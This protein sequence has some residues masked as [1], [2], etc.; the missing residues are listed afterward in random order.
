MRAYGF[1]FLAFIG[2][3]TAW[4]SAAAPAITVDQD[5]TAHFP[6]LDIPFS[7]FASAEA[8]K[9]YLGK[10]AAP[11]L[12]GPTPQ[13]IASVRENVTRVWTPYLD[14]DIQLYPVTIETATIAGVATDVVTPVGGVAPKNRDKILINLH[15]GGFFL[16][17]HI[18]GKIESVPIAGLGKYK[19]ITV[20][21]RQGTENKFPAASEDV[22]A[23]Y[24]ELLKQYK[25]KNI[26][27]Y[28]CSAGGFLTAEAMAWF[29]KEKL[30]L[31]GAIGIFCAS[32]G[33]WT[34]GDSTYFTAPYER[35]MPIVKASHPTVWDVAYF[36]DA[37]M[38][39]PLV[40]PIR[41]QEML[42]KFPPTLMITATR[43]FALSSA[44]YTHSQLVKLGVEADLHVWEGVGHQ[45][46]MDPDMPESKEAYAV[47]VKFFDR[48]LGR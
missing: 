47:A 8:L 19:V 17:A 23:V 36:S 48:H 5:G 30:P 1:A 39:D 15:G 33:G 42:A 29:Q 26:G 13:D 32:A 21:Y 16:G 41:S 9:T 38:N 7:S 10:L 43:D 24:K 18:S 14:R 12:M 3:A 35:G 2:L 27:I 25:P 4:P 45:F 6:P 22:A 44:V 31:P 28:G 46:F 20:D 34:G 11:S 40:S 37:D